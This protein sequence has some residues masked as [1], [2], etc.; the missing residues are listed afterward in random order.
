MRAHRFD[1]CAGVG[2]RELAAARR[3]DQPEGVGSGVQGGARV[4]FGLEAANLDV[5]VGGGG[6]E[7]GGRSDALTALGVPVTGRI[8]LIIPPNPYNRF[9][10]E[11]KAHRSGHLL[12][13]QGKERLPEQDETPIVAGMTNAQIA[14]V[15]EAQ[16]AAADATAGIA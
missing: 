16:Q 5:G 13:P 2:G 14:E 11:T 9:Y 7:P 10:L 8:P 4:S 1:Q 12:D 15:A 3:E 6:E